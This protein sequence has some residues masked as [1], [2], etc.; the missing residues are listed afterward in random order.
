[1][2]TII[3][4]ENSD[5]LTAVRNFLRR[6][7]ESGIVESLF[8]PLE[9]EGGALIPALV[10]DPD[11]LAHANPL[12]PVMPI[13]GARAISVLT[14]SPLSTEP[15]PGSNQQIGEN[16]GP[17]A[18]HMGIVLRSCE[19]RALIELIKLQQASLEGV[20]LIGLDCPGTYEV[21]EYIESQRNG[22]FDL[23]DY[24][25]AAKEG[26]EPA[27]D[28]LALRPAC[29]MCTRPLPEQADIHL[30][31]FGAETAQGI[32]VTLNDEIAAQLQMAETDEAGA[33][34]RL[35]VV[36]Q[37]IAARTQAREK[38]LAA[39]RARMNSN[40]GMTGIFST[41]IRCHN[42][43]TVC[44]ICYCKTCL[45]KTN[46][47]NHAPDHYLT[48]AQR[49]GATRLLGDTMLFHMTRL[50]HMA[51]SCVSCGMCMSACPVDI[52]VGAVFSAVGDQVQAAF[53]Y[54]PG[55]DVA[56]PL[57]LITFQ[58]EEWTEVGEA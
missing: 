47:F 22:G 55:R 17:G 11:R 58:V 54:T 25:S 3:P 8:V 31:L 19:I 7:L 28:G 30:H 9:T 56:E 10:T 52:P 33:D 35:S 46:A 38:E 20:V 51:S 57:P 18:A 4:V 45:F 42:C 21:V 15:L 29:Q 48:A 39:I 53:D 34:R 26:R 37:V 49:K 6:L 2:N 16:G 41:C 24:L 14:G 43:M 5:T 23:A 13:N 44:P 36:E 27:F 32:P 40:G 50:N 12:S 1:M